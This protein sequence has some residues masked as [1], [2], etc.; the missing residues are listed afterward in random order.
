M[1][2][3]ADINHFIVLINQK[4]LKGLIFGETVKGVYPVF[5]INAYRDVY[6]V[7][8]QQIGYLTFILRMKDKQHGNGSPAKGIELRDEFFPFMQLQFAT[9]TTY[10]INIHDDFIW[11][12]RQRIR[13]GILPE[14]G[15]YHLFGENDFF[16]LPFFYD[17]GDL[18]FLFILTGIKKGCNNGDMK[19]KDTSHQY[20]NSLSKPLHL[21]PPL[22][23]F[24]SRP[25]STRILFRLK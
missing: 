20:E 11:G 21:I 15:E 13:Y 14:L 18:F 16:S 9:R 25:S 22:S 10:G 8:F 6:V 3:I 7:P 4:T 12:F 5:F 2:R 1:N 19:N 17:L 24:L 23:M